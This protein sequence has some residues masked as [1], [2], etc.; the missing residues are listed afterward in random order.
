VT[1][2]DKYRWLIGYGVT[3]ILLFVPEA[4]I[5]GRFG[6]K[7]PTAALIAPMAFFATIL[8]LAGPFLYK[9]RSQARESGDPRLMMA[10]VTVLFLIILVM[11]AH[12]AAR[13]GVVSVET[14]C[15]YTFTSLIFMPICGAIA[16]LIVKKWTVRRFGQKV[17]R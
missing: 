1:C 2:S 3:I 17:E 8:L 4:L 6:L 14:A 9:G 10:T 12:F 7:L 16:Y 5:I 11:G 13:L 15:G